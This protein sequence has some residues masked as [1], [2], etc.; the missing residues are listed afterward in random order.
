MNDVSNK[1]KLLSRKSL[2]KPIT[3][4]TLIWLIIF[5]AS[6]LSLFTENVY[7]YM[8]LILVNISQFLSLTVIGHDGLHS[9][10]SVSKRLNKIFN[11]YFVIWPFFATTSVNK[12]NHLQHHSLHG[13][14]NDPDLYKYSPKIYT[15]SEILVTIF[16]L[17]SIITSFSRILLPSQNV[18]KETKFLKKR[19]L[20]RYF[21]IL[22]MNLIIICVFINK[23]SIIDYL[24]LWTLP[25]FIASRLDSIRV[26]SEHHSNSNKLNEI[27]RTFS[28]NLIEKIFLCPKNMNFHSVHHKWPNIPYY[29]LPE[30]NEVLYREC[31]KNSKEPNI[32][33]WQKSYSN[34]YLNKASERL[35]S[36]IKAS[37]PS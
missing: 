8:I 2:F 22:F 34:Y 31:F 35:K 21:P 15:F 30:A 18:N 6:A 26:F 32:F 24:L 27:T 9:N 13:S 37:F 1:I 10:L 7:I 29:N 14:L 17:N 3:D 11:D 12:Y 23:A 16:S 19:S 4:V 33:S 20:L 28:P 36:R 5:I 25:I